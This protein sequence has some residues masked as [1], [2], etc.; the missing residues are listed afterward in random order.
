MSISKYVTAFSP[1]ITERFL[2]F[3]AQLYNLSTFAILAYSC[4]KH[5]AFPSVCAKSPQPS[6]PPSRILVMSRCHCL[7]IYSLACL[8]TCGLTALSPAKAIETPLIEAI[9]NVGQEGQG[10]AQAAAAWSKIAAAAPA[11]LRT[12][13]AGMNGANP[14]AQ[15][16]L[17]AAV[18]TAASRA[19]AAGALPKED[20]AAFIKDTSGDAA[21]RLLAYELLLQHAP[22]LATE[23]TPGLLHDPAAELRL[24]PVANWIEKAKA[25]Q[26]KGDKPAAIAAYQEGLSGARD[27]EQINALTKGLRDLGEKV[28]LPRHFGFLMNWHLIAPFTN[29]DRAGFDTVF[30]PE[31]KIDLQAAYP[32]KGA[33]AKW[34]SYESKDDYG[35]IDF[36][37]PFTML[38]EV[39]GYAYTEFDSTEA[40]SAEIRLG[41]KNGWKV[42]LNGELLFG[43]DEYHRGMKLDQYKLPCQLKQ[44]KN[45][46][47]VKC[48]QNE[49]TEQWTVEWRFQLR[50]CD[51]T[52]TA[53]LAKQP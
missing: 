13:L 51:A 20:L 53:I 18:E 45:T 42:W 48:C 26:E 32:G 8:F 34:Q 49:Q 21:P 22:D 43:R 9:R 40:R 14:L 17:R 27:E 25:L 11:D 35:M 23:L 4:S 29:A 44:G 10:N 46:L 47:L 36:N 1:A 52:G 31:E 30:P 19:Q 15:N 50:I 2:I 41:C 7:P 12:I 5:F 28:D 33:E 37:E 3:A 24:Y 16:W 38:K 6:L 39:T